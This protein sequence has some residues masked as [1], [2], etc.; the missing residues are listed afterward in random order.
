MAPGVALLRHA[1]SRHTSLSVKPAMKIERKIPF[2]MSQTL[3]NSWLGAS[4]M[5]AFA[6]LPNSSKDQAIAKFLRSRRPDLFDTNF[7]GDFLIWSLGKPCPAS[8]PEIRSPATPVDLRMSPHL[9]R[10]VQSIACGMD[11]TTT[12]DPLWTAVLRLRTS[13]ADSFDFGMVADGLSYYLASL[14]L[15]AQPE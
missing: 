12:P 9:H 1:F 7:I 4:K 8:C 13:N 10:A 2:P 5:S 6:Q 3:E 14:E 11:Y 15:Q